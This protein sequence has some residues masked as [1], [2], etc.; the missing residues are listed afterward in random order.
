MGLRK[1][2]AYIR[3]KRPYTR[4][5]KFNKLSYVKAIPTSKVVRY[6]MGDLKKDF[7]KQ[8]DLVSR[9][10][11]QI[12]HNALESARILVNRVLSKV[13]GNNYRLRLRLYPHHIL[14]ENKM[15]TGAGAD[16]MQQGMAQAFGKPIGLAA[17]VKEN[18]PIFSAYVDSEYV[19]VAKVAL[20]MAAPR[21]PCRCGIVI[22]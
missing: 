15:L 7:P 12:R 13:L 3:V 20:K 8:V 2:I 14:R 22:N 1:G 5:S 17:Q 11:V 10:R 19:D 6:N 18:Q 4:K 16:R 9:E 21:L